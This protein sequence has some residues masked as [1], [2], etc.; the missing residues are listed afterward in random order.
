M[1]YRDNSLYLLLV[2]P[3]K[4]TDL[5]KDAPLILDGE[6]GLLEREDVRLIGGVHGTP[7]GGEGWG[8]IPAQHVLV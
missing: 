3:S 5:P 1:P 4:L 7:A 8:D 6:R 2:T